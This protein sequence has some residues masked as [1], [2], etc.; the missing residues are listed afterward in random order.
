[1]P[2]KLLSSILFAALIFSQIFCTS[3]HINE[4]RINQDAFP[5][6]FG[7]P[8][9]I[10]LIEKRTS[11]INKGGMNNYIQKSFEKNYS[12]AFEMATADEI[13]NDP[14]YKNTKVYRY[15]LTDNVWTSGS[16]VVTTTTNPSRTTSS[17]EIQYNYAYSLDFH[18]FDRA[19]EKNYPTLGVSSNVPAKAINR[20]SVLLNKK[21]KS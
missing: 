15:V 16:K 10:L 3:S 11:G 1:M 4:S 19:E 2:N 14:K 5:A 20:T 13:R 17:T 21:L 8:G 9:Q 12:G 18:L 6:H 7:E